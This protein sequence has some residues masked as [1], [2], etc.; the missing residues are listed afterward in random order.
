MHRLLWETVG[1]AQGHVTQPREWHT[2]ESF[3]DETL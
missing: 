2:E 1:R 3:A